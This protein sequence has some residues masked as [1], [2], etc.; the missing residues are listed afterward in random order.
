LFGCVF[1]N[2]LFPCLSG[3]DL[4]PQNVSRCIQGQSFS[5]LRTLKPLATKKTLLFC[6]RCRHLAEI[7]SV[8]YNCPSP[9]SCRS[10]DSRTE[11]FP[12]CTVSLSCAH[13]LPPAGTPSHALEVL[14]GDVEDHF[15]DS[16]IP[17][18]TPPM[19]HPPTPPTLR[20]SVARLKQR[21][22]LPPSPLCFE[23]GFP[24]IVETCSSFFVPGTADFHYVYRSSSV[25]FRSLFPPPPFFF[26]RV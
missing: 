11:I 4:P 26:F 7:L 25:L 24:P 1:L 23:Q 5:Y 9:V 3:S 8:H 16:G 10:Q 14:L 13:Y 17:I 18:T 19:K 22:E 12:F 6:Q 20:H 2:P 15:F 21:S